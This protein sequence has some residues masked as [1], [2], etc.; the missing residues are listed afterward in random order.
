MS[1]RRAE[2]IYDVYIWMMK[3]HGIAGFAFAIMFLAAGCSTMNDVSGRTPL[4]ADGPH[5]YGGTRAIFCGDGFTGGYMKGISGVNLSGLSGSDP[6]VG[7][8]ICGIILA[9]VATDVASSL[10]TDTILLP[11][12]LS[13]ARD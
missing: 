2:C 3:P 7:A 9:P 10:V 1:G 12:T 6:R 13:K 4:G 11:F 5:V 8:L